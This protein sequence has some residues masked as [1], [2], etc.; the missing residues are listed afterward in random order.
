MQFT[1]FKATIED[2]LTVTHA[3]PPERVRPHVPD[4]LE[5]DTI[6]IPG[7]G[8][9]A[10]V[11]TACFLNR[12]AHWAAL[13]EPG[14][15]YRQTTYQIYVKRRGEAAAFLVGTY[16]ESGLPFLA[17]RLAM[18]NVWEADFDVSVAYDLH[19]RAYRR[20]YCKVTSNHGN[21][22]VEAKAPGPEPDAHPPFDTGRQ[23]SRYIT[24]RPI[25]YFWTFGGVL[26][27]MRVEHEEMNPVEAW[28]VTAQFDL[29]EELRILTREEFMRHYAIL[30]QPEIGFTAYPPSRVL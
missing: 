19:R 14:V 9:V 24:D 4:E 29:W 2:L 26:G 17:E 30:I 5:L 1:R 21:T 10:L 16:V 23:M 11:S 6:E 13:E 8:Q 7:S 12:N 27:S 15:D 3:V 28:L 22:V 18:E 25:S 20:Y